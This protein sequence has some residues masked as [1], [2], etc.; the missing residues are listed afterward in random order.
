MAPPAPS[1]E[2]NLKAW[3]RGS[4]TRPKLRKLHDFGLDMERSDDDG[5]FYITRAEGLAREFTEV[6]VGDRL[7]KF[8]DRDPS[9]FS[10]EDIHQIL[11]KELKISFETL[12]PEIMS[13]SITEIEI[14]IEIGDVVPLAGMEDESLNGRDV[15][16]LRE[17]KNGKWLVKVLD[18]EAKILVHSSNLSFELIPEQLEQREYVDKAIA[19]TVA[20]E[21]C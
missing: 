12:H 9:E 11:K 21:A 6:K 16:V 10:L 5:H 17:S 13:E 4:L 7:L 18:S 1:L 15:Q 14:E 8:Q 19:D 3:V 2:Y 20:V